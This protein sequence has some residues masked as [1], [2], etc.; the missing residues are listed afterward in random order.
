LYWLKTVVVSDSEEYGLKECLEFGWDGNC[1]WSSSD[2]LPRWWTPH[3]SCSCFDGIEWINGTKTQVGR[4]ASKKRSWNARFLQ[5]PEPRSG[6]LIDVHSS[7]LSKMLFSI[8]GSWVRGLLLVP[9]WAVASLKLPKKKLKL[10]VLRWIATKTTCTGCLRCSV[11]FL[12]ESCA[13]EN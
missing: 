9:C 10:L 6:G 7:M 13:G 12:N 1:P 4:R 11:N 3:Y 2:R 5:L 8:Q